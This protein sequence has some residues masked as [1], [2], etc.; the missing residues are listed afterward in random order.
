VGI[1]SALL[2]AL[3]LIVLLMVL[4]VVTGMASAP[5]SNTLT[6]QT[7]LRMR[8]HGAN[9]IDSL[10]NTLPS[11]QGVKRLVTL[12]ALGWQYRNFDLRLSLDY[13]LQ[14]TDLAR[15]GDGDEQVE[16]PACLNMLGI[17][18]RNIGA[19]P[20]AM[21]C[22]FEALNRASTL[23]QRKE[24][25]YA[26]NNI[27]DVYRLQG[28]F[29]WASENIQKAIAEFDALGDERGKGYGFMR[30]GEV[31]E[32]T[33]K[34]ND[35]YI[36]YLRAFDIRSALRDT[37]Q[38]YVTLV[39]IG[40]VHQRQHRYDEALRCYRQA[41]DYMSSIGSESD[42][43]G[44]KRAIAATYYDT[45][46]YA[47]AVR[48]GREAL[49]IGKKSGF[50]I[51]IQD[52]SGVLWR[53]FAAL[54]KYKEALEQQTLFLAMR[55]S[56]A[57]EQSVKQIA[58][59]QINYEIQRKEAEVELMQRNER[60]IRWA[61]IAGLVLALGLVA[62]IANRYRLK[63][64]STREILRQQDLLTAQSREIQLANTALQ[65]AND[66]AESLL[67]SILPRPI[68][69]RMKQGE[70]RIAEQFDGAAVLF[71]DLVGFT[72][73][74]SV[75]QPHHVVELLDE[76]FS[77]FDAIALRYGVEK[78]K[79]I[80]D[81]Y[82]AVAGVPVPL[83]ENTSAIANTALDMLAALEHINA[84][85]QSRPQSEG[86]TAPLQL[87]IGIHTGTV[88]AGI[89][90]KNKFSYDLWGDT[91]NTASRLETHG[92]AGRIHISEVSEQML[93]KRFVL[94]ERGMVEVKSK[95]LMRTYFLLERKQ[96]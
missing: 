43:G 35:A 51:D 19:Y 45:R 72:E 14:S 12:R 4:I 49:E 11:T 56:L 28:N 93:R 54:G 10:K 13:I 52:A 78:I 89:I 71:A 79:T 7:K 6:A 87:R 16:L 9:S 75:M 50:P 64:R 80:G 29:A 22:F 84:Q 62:A 36:Y 41:L 76:I 8:S 46:D 3:V 82:L 24:I 95:G 67:Q 85:R 37:T 60:I 59:L 15:R 5:A 34:F 48:Y 40:T 17:A 32:A 30:L 58:M 31:Y 61:L 69:V 57:N 42:V 63:Q 1:V 94:E 2:A 26:Y 86:I 53:S 55:D 66:Q 68:A 92:E 25:A 70:M 33:S 83:A 91:V 77:A 74:S 38:I 39:R 88:I 20:R 73:M 44:T 21:E 96:A 23:A 81:G 90:G 27:G 65:A 18:Y 47:A